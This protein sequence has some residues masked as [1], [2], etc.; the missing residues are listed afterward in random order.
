MKNSKKSEFH[1]YIFRTKTL[2]GSSVKWWLNR[3]IT[4]VESGSTRLKRTNEPWPRN[5]STLNTRTQ[6]IVGFS[7]SRSVQG[8][9][10]VNMVPK[11]KIFRRDFQ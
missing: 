10:K 5:I 1:D 8:H 4:A 6:D 9:L 2:N 3:V 7:I 11:A